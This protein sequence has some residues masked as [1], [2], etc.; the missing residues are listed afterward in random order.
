MPDQSAANKTVADLNTLLATAY[1]RAGMPIHHGYSADPAHWCAHSATTSRSEMRDD[2][3]A[4]LRASR[5]IAQQL[6]SP[7]KFSVYACADHGWRQTEMRAP[8]AVIM[9]S[10]RAALPPLTTLGYYNDHAPTRR[11]IPDLFVDAIKHLVGSS[12]ARVRPSA[13]D[14]HAPRIA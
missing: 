6:W 14:S 8:Y 11:A 10:L 7:R 13:P 4:A 5:S 12:A 3:I 9:A 1:A 2:A